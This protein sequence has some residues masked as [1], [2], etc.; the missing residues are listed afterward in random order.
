MLHSLHSSLLDCNTLVYI[1]DISGACKL[2]IADVIHEVDYT[3]SGN[4]IADADA[5]W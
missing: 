2:V 1:H 4:V 5:L 3:R